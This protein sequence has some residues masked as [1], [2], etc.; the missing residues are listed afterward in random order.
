MICPVCGNPMSQFTVERKT[1]GTMRGIRCDACKVS[2]FLSRDAL[3]RLSARETTAA[4]QPTARHEPAAER[5][6]PLA[7]KPTVEV[8]ARRQ[9]PEPARLPQS[10][11]ELF[12]DW[13]SAPS[14]TSK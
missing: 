11:F 1:K 4:Q 14:D 6:A 5:P 8:G 2:T 3:Q 10:L 13:L 9:E 12:V 7:Q